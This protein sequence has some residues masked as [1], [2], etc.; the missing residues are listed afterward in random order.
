MKN[1][2]IN[3]L[4]IFPIMIKLAPHKTT[5]KFFHLVNSI[6]NDIINPNIFF[7]IIILIYFKSNNIFEFK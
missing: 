7:K 4:V 2:K 6:L 5:N 1:S 3:L